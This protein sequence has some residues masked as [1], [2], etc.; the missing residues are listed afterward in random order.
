MVAIGVQT[1][2]GFAQFEPKCLINTLIFTIAMDDDSRFLG[3]GN[4]GTPD[5]IWSGMKLE[6]SYNQRD[7]V[8]L[9]LRLFFLSHQ[10]RY[11]IFWL[12]FSK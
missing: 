5:V 7:N 6:V 12:G 1:A 9:E 8:G 2:R 3:L 4:G 11:D 10:K